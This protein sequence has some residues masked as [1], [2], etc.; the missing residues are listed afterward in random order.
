M[1]VTTIFRRVLTAV[2]LA[3]G[4]LTVPTVASAMTY[5]S[6]MLPGPLYF[7]TSAQPFCQ[8][9]LTVTSQPTHVRMACSWD[10]RGSRWFYVFLPNGQEG[11]VKSSLVP[12]ITR[13]ASPPCSSINWLNASNWAIARIGRD[14]ASVGDGVLPPAP[15]FWS[16][17]CL[18]FAGDAWRPWGGIVAP[19]NANSYPNN[20]WD[21]FTRNHPSR[22]HVGGRPPRGALVFW[23]TNP[24]H[25]AISVGNWRTVGTQG[26]VPQRLPVWDYDVNSKPYYTGWIMPQPPT[27]P[28]NS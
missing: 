18:T 11:Y 16:G 28:H 26:N 15:F 6:T 2:T 4:I 13:T 10:D 1:S 19:T 5:P 17:Y 23:G 8:S 7:C 14:T 9:P 3:V 24:W 22:V 27:V 25:V 12:F 20:V 21:W